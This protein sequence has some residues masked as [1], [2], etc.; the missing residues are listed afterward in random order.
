[1][2]WIYLLIGIVLIIY[3]M[4][5]TIDSLKIF[6]AGKEDKLGADIKILTSN[7]CVIIL[8]IFM[9]YNEAKKHTG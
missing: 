4:W 8:G 1:M 6:N 5:S 9:I 3:G 7:I 2:N